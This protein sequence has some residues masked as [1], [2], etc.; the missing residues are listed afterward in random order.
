M[1][2][3]SVARTMR[4]AATELGDEYDF[5]PFYAIALM[6]LERR[7]A[8]ELC[9]RAVRLYPTDSEGRGYCVRRYAIRQAA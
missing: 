6:R 9:E 7:A 5:R 1:I 3:Q 8:I 4:Q 2:D